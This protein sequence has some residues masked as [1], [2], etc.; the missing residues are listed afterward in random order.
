M[1]TLSLELLHDLADTLALDELPELLSWAATSPAAPALIDATI[2]E[3][4]VPEPELDADGVPVPGSIF[5]KLLHYAH[6]EHV[7]HALQRHP[8]ASVTRLAEVVA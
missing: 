8:A 6:A 1:M 2:V 7:L 5:R 4:G 3:L